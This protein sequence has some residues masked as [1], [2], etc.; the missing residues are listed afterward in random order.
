MRTTSILRHLFITSLVF[1]AAA[2]CRG[3]DDG[4]DVADDAGDDTGDD[5]VDPNDVTI[6]EIQQGE[7]DEGQT[8][9]VLGVIVTA[10]DTYGERDDGSR[11]GTI[12]VQEPD[13]GPYSGVLVF[14]GPAEQVATLEVGDVIDIAGA[15]VTEFALDADLSGRKTTELQPGDSG[16]MQI[17]RVSSGPEPEPELVDVIAIAQ[18]D[19]TSPSPNAQDNEWEKWEGVLIRVENVAQV[20]DIDPISETMNPNFY[21]I[22]LTPGRFES[23]TS[24]TA[25]PTSAV[26]GTCFASITGLGDYFFNWKLQP[27]STDD[28]VSGGTGCPAQEEGDAAC[29]N[30]DDDDFDGFTDCA[31]FSCQDTAAAC[32]TATTV[33]DIQAGTATGTV[34]LEDVIVTGRGR[35]G[36]GGA[37]GVWVADAGAAAM[38]AGVFVFTGTPLPDEAFVV[39]SRVNVTGNVFEFDAQL[40]EVS[41]PVTVTAGTAGT[42]TVTPLAVG[43]VATLSDLTTGEPYEGVLVTIE[44]VEVTVSGMFDQVTFTDGAGTIIMDDAGY[45]YASADF[46]VGTCLASITGHMHWQNNDD[47]RTI[48]PRTAADVVAGGACD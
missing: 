19:G 20:G 39:G 17:T 12:Y 10:K 2:A 40:T 26:D 35:T 27:R 44:N 47:I 33:A 29:S 28:F 32:V 9:T 38:G 25:F 41:T 48:I 22:H 30:G 4:D 36:S 6:Y 8:I 31:D 16:T 15:G 24:L 18:L 21:A 13:G 37:A 45:D 11:T 46:P 14:G 43:A 34:Q 5:T 23:D 7:V 1:S 42:T 3:G